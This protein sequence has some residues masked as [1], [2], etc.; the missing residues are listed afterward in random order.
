MRFQLSVSAKMSKV[1]GC[2][3]NGAS[4]PAVGRKPPDLQQAGAGHERVVEIVGR[5]LEGII[6]DIDVSAGAEELDLV[7]VAELAED[8]DGL[9]GLH[10][11]A[12]EGDVL[13][14][15]LLHPGADGVHLGF[16]DGGAVGLVD[17][18]EIAL[19]NRAAQD[20][21]VVREQVAGGLAEQEAQRAAVDVA[22]GVGAIVEKL[23]VAVVEHAEL[24]PFGDVVDLG[25]K[26]VV[27]AFERKGGEHVQQ[28]GPFLELLVSVR[29]FAINSEHRLC[30]VGCQYTKLRKF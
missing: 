11:V 13:L 9:V 10:F 20:D 2:S 25:G 28:G 30:S 12:A 8:A 21:A 4:C 14:H 27:G 29:V 18:A 17:I 5:V 24:E 6:G 1:L 16:R 3:K 15:E 19:G 7:V 23:D 26:D 22:A